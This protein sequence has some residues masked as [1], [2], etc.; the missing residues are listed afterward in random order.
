MLTTE[1]ME[2][3]KKAVTK[4]FVIVSAVI[5]IALLAMY[6]AGVRIDMGPEEP[7]TE[8]LDYNISVTIGDETTMSALSVEFSIENG[9]AVSATIDGESVSLAELGLSFDVGEMSPADEPL[10]MFLSIDG[11]SIEAQRYISS[12]TEIFAD[13]DGTVYG[14][15]SVQEDRIVEVIL[16]GWHQVD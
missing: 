9:E 1:D 12:G 4:K 11:E 16:D 6:L 5:V 3:Q 14:I 10:H 7:T 15:H 2:A 8:T 13:G